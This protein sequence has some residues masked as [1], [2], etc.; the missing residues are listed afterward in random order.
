MSEAD[1]KA[2]LTPGTFSE[3]LW[4]NNPVFVML[5]GMCSVLAVTN[6]AVNA[7]A[8]GLST[9]FALVA[10]AAMVSGLRRLIPRPVRI[11]TYVVIIATFVTLIDY[12]IQV[13]SL[14]LYNALGAFIQLI[15][16]NCLILGR[17]EAHASKNRVWPAVV[18]ALG[19]GLGFTLA[20]LAMGTVREILG[21]GSLFGVRLFGESFAPW[22]IMVLPPG[23]FFVLGGWL[24]LFS[25]IKHRRQARQQQ[26]EVQHVH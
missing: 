12:A 3:G 17:A 5:L 4:R 1:N 13:I 26:L 8:M 19:M 24:L 18:N 2:G 6:S 11:A 9:T 25:I 14:A 21:S 15:V 10:S 20:L 23:G 16:V 22:V 7:L